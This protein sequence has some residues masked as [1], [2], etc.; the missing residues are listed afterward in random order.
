[1]QW[2]GL[3]VM[4]VEL[5]QQITVQTDGYTSCFYFLLCFHG[6]ACNGRQFTHYTIIDLNGEA[7]SIHYISMA[8]HAVRSGRKEKICV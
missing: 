1:M 6:Y 4:S 8:A 2:N 3:F 5:N 7:R